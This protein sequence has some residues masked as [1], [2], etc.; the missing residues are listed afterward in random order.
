MTGILCTLSPVLAD[1]NHV[2]LEFR[3]GF[4]PKSDSQ[5]SLGIAPVGSQNESTPVSFKRNSLVTIPLHNTTNHQK[6]SALQLDA[7]YLDKNSQSL[8]Q[9]SRVACVTLGAVIG[10]GGI[11]LFS[12]SI[13][14]KDSGNVDITIN[15]K[16]ETPPT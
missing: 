16:A 6:R 9:R 1:S 7:L 2:Y 12:E 4:G 15:T 10:V 8:C 3:L 13:R 11:Y 5:L 14:D